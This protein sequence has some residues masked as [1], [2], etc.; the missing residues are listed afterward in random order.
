MAHGV[1]ERLR[2]RTLGDDRRDTEARNLEPAEYV[3]LRQ[4]ADGADESV[5][6][7]GVGVRTAVVAGTAAVERALDAWRAL[8]ES[9]VDELLGDDGSAAA[10]Y[11][12]RRVRET[13]TGRGTKSIPVEIAPSARTPQP[14]L[15]VTSRR[16]T[17]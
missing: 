17:R 3:S 2:I 1:P 8:P 5:H 11:R 6:V 10:A 12:L 9:R 7:V 13:V 16:S 15:S 14:A 4:Y